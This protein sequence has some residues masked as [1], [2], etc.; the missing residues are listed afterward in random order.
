MASDS[1]GWDGSPLDAEAA[2]ESAPIVVVG[3]E[4]VGVAASLLGEHVDV[5]DASVRCS[6]GVVVGDDEFGPSVDRASQ[7][8]EFGD[9]DVCAV[10]EEHDQASA[11]VA[12][13]SGGEHFSEQFLGDDGCADFA[14]GVAGGEQVEQPRDAL[15]A[16]PIPSGQEHPAASVERIA[17]VAPVTELFLLH[18]SAHVIDCGVRELDGVEVIDDEGG[19]GEVLDECGAV[20]GRRI[21]GCERD[22]FAPP[23]ASFGE[24]TR[25]NIT[26]TAPDDLEESVRVQVDDL[27]R[28]H[29]AMCRG[30][31]QEPLLVNADPTHPLE[32]CRVVDVRVGVLANGCVGGVPAHTELDRRGRDREPLDVHHASKTLAG[33]FAQHRS[34]GDRVN[35]LGPRRHRT[36]RL[37]TSQPTAGE[38]QHRRRPRNRQI[39]HLTAAAAVADRTAPAAVAPAH[40]RRGLDREPPLTIALHLAANDQSGHPDERCRVFATVINGQGSLLQQMSD[41]CRMARPLAALVDPYRPGPDITPT[42]ASSRRAAKGR[43]ENATALVAELDAAF[44]TRPMAH[45]RERLD[46]HDVWWSPIQSIAEVIDDPQAAPAFIQMANREGEREFRSVATPVDFAGYELRPG[47]VPHLGEHTEEVL[48]DL[49]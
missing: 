47:I 6:T 15:V 5:L 25:E 37:S 29:R 40:T 20:A 39:P 18:T 9:L 7:T 2:D 13:V 28:E 17:L 26:G 46:H 32:A 35:P 31:V 49:G 36:Q 33:S 43:L 24:P 34:R 30:R 14:V 12:G 3:S 19:V 42:H 23:L 48:S 45:W 44:A 27:G 21:E 22:L 4:A 8:R 41:T 1:A 38:H 11:G 10:L 16:E